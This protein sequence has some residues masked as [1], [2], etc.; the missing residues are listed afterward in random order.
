MIPNDN[1]YVPMVADFVGQVARKMGFEDQD[2]RAAQLGVGHALTSI[3][4]NFFEPGQRAM[5]EISCERVPVGLKIVIRDQG[6]PFDPGQLSVSIHNGEQETGGSIF[7]VKEY[8]DEVMLNNLGR[9]GKETVLIKRFKHND[10]TDYYEACE[11]EP[12]PQAPDE[13][14]TVPEKLGFVIR[15]MA[16]SEAVEVAKCIYK[17]YGYSYFYE[18]MYYPE[19]LSELNNQGRMHS[20][21]AVTLDGEI[22]GHS[23]LSFWREGARIAEMGQ[24][25]VKPEFRSQGLFAKLN[26]YLVGKA[27][28][29]SL[30]G[31]FGQAVTNHNRSQRVVLSL[32]LGVCAITLG[33]VPADVTFKGITE[34]LPQRES[35]V[36]HFMYL[37]NVPSPTIFAPPQHSDIIQNLYLQ[38]GV[39]PVLGMPAV[40]AIEDLE[41]NSILETKILGPLNVARIELVNYGRNVVGEIRALLKELCLKRL[42]VIILY[43]DLCDP[44]TYHFTGEFEALGFLFSGILPGATRQGDALI[45]QYLNNVSIDYD[46]IIVESSTAKDL[47]RYIIEDE[48]KRV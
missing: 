21:V 40:T 23:A 30:M 32:G 12:Y 7:G 37:A 17:A 31:V 15:A 39:T 3:M 42:D 43:L 1:A 48:R 47:L 10:I 11:L 13:R 14:R 9:S 16:P 4:Q 44:G 35:L 8:V 22:V 24:G 33:Y 28:E 27:A 45:L 26:E 36:I 6:I 29:M 25:V 5:L 20:A 46:R 18:Y 2:A 38:L 19:Q 41:A 34:S